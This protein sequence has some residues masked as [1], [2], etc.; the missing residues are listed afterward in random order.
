MDQKI[1]VSDVQNYCENCT[2]GLLVHGTVSSYVNDILQEGLLIRAKDFPTVLSSSCGLLK[3]GTPITEYTWYEP[4]AEGESVSLILQVPAE[5]LNEIKSKGLP[6]T[7]KNIF[8]VICEEIELQVP[9][10][11]ETREAYRNSQEHQDKISKL[12]ELEGLFGPKFS[13]YGEKPGTKYT[14]VGIPPKYICA[15][16]SEKQVYYASEQVQKFINKQVNNKHTDL[17]DEKPLTLYDTDEL[18]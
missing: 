9:D 15:I 1:E 3:D 12:G 14:H 16:T 17:K 8:D 6:L 11:E 7:Q 13:K 5:I 10:N 2:D 18:F 4:R